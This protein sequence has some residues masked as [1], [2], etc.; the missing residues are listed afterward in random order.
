[1]EPDLGDFLLAF[2]AAAKGSLVDTIPGGGDFVKNLSF[3]FQQAESELL[4]E[5]G[6]SEVRH[7][8]GH[9][10]Q[11]AG[12]F[13]SWLAQGF[14]CQVRYIPV[15]AALQSEQFLPV[16]FEIGFGHRHPPMIALAAVPHHLTLS[17]CSKPVK[18]LDQEDCL[19][20]LK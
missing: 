18:D 14:I 11:I 8:D 3:V 16:V 7:M 4:F 10:G 13:L 6:G 1:M 17:R 9:M 19:L 5:T 2:F 12:G 20:S 15:K